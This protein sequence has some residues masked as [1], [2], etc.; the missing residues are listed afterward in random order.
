[1]RD[2]MTISIDN[3]KTRHS[4]RRLQCTSSAYPIGGL[5]RPRLSTVLLN[6]LLVKRFW[7]LDRNQSPIPVPIPSRFVNALK[8]LPFAQT[9]GY[10]TFIDH[11]WKHPLCLIHVI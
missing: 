4:R 10:S 7:P 1:C 8:A 11:N 5:K 6:V 2:H 9:C 3:D